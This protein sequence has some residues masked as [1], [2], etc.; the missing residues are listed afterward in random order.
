MIIWHHD[1][2]C[3]T[4]HFVASYFDHDSPK[5]P[6]SQIMKK[7][8]SQFSPVLNIATTKK[9]KKFQKPW[10]E[11][12]SFL[13]CE[14]FTA[15][16]LQQDNLSRI[17]NAERE[18]QIQHPSCL[19]PSWFGNWH[20]DC[21]QASIICKIFPQQLDFK[22]FEAHLIGAFKI[23]NTHRGARTHDHKVKGL[24]LYRLS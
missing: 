18:P 20:A 7:A 5:P 2:F 15:W 4:I 3:L 17:A 11:N 23:N 24:A 10:T 16:L 1:T 14:S 22:T 8:S 9:L 13:H 6:K 19:I 12:V 21:F